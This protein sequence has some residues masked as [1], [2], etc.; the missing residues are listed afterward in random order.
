MTLSL[1]LPDGIR[2]LTRSSSSCVPRE[3]DHV[4]LNGAYF[5]VTA[6]VWQFGEPHDRDL[7]VPELPVDIHL[8]KALPP[9]INQG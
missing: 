7:T 3:G 1:I 2:L 6:V 5:R 9:Q 4:F 8:Q